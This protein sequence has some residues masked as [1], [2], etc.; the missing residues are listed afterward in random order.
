ML[1]ATRWHLIYNFFFLFQIYYLHLKRL[2]AYLYNSLCLLIKKRE[3]RQSRRR[4]RM[5]KNKQINKKEMSS[6]GFEMWC[7]VV[8]ICE[9]F[10][11]CSEN[12]VILF[13]YSFNS[14]CVFWLHAIHSCPRRIPP[15]NY[16][17]NGLRRWTVNHTCF[18]S[19]LSFPSSID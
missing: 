7:H 15:I 16:G 17:C 9:K 8:V 13:I 5:R 18:A 12:V 6:I 4:K 3:F 11:T 1:A 19:S 10:W 2:V 14:V